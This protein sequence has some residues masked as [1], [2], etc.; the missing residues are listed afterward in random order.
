MEIRKGTKEDAAVL[1]AINVEVQQI[2]ADAHPR[3]FKQ[4]VDETYAVQFMRERLEEPDQFFY[5]ARLIGVDVG[6]IYARMVDRP[7]NP[8]M[9]AWKFMYIDQMCVRQAYRRMG[10]GERLL[11]E[12]FHLAQAMGIETVALDSWSFNQVALA[13]FK[14]QGLETYNERLWIYLDAQPE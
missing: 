10:C 13:F 12:V 5:I 4:P 2:H 14:G 3:I 9:H 8:F 7:E 6:Y 1:S 11:A